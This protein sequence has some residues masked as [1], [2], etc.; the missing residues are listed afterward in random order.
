VGICVDA[1]VITWCNITLACHAS[2]IEQQL[3]NIMEEHWQI[4]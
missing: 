1:F 2:D 4:F 3:A